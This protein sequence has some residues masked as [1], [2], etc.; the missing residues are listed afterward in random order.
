MIL[1]IR[2]FADAGNLEK[3]RLVL[4]ATADTD[5]GNYAIFRS[6]RA[7]N[8]KPIS[9]SKNAYWFPDIDVSEGDLVVLYTRAGTARRKTLTNG[10]TAHFYY[11]NQKTSFWGEDK[12]NIA[13]LIQTGDWVSRAPTSNQSPEAHED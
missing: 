5:I 11:W 4:R 8:G 7:S 12:N 9:G 2:S 10:K 3:E 13:V 6:K 1:E